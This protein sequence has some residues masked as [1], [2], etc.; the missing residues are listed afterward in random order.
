MVPE[1]TF[2]LE[3]GIYMQIKA[4]CDYIKGHYIIG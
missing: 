3:I 1:H 4:L 2:T